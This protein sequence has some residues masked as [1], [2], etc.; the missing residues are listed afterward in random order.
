MRQLFNNL[1]RSIAK[2]FAHGFAQ[3]P[4]SRPADNLRLE[5]QQRAMIKSADMVQE[6]MSNALFC[7]TKLTHLEYALSLKGDG[8]IAEFGVYKGTTINFI[9][10]RCPD[11]T[12]YGFDSFEGLPEHWSG[13]RYSRRN[14]NRKGKPPKV[15]SNVELVIGWFNET[16][17]SF[18]ERETEP[19]L[20]QSFETI[21]FIASRCPDQTVYGFDSFEGLPEHWSGNRYSRRNFNRKGKPPKVESNVELVIGGFNETLPSFLERETE[22]FGFVHIDCDI[23]SSTKQIFDL[24]APRIAPGCIIV[25]DEFFNYHGF[26]QHEYK[27]FFEFVKAN[28][29]DYEFISFSGQE[30]GVRIKGPQKVKK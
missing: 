11:Q 6:R 22:P 14:F 9:A 4:L 18:L 28:A 21:N 1:F 17:P 23:Y 25:F 29:L 16:L 12:V 13:N 3:F 30:A 26:E 15:E 5:L 2:D 20:G 24:I 10:S 7:H 19:M 27:A 8:A